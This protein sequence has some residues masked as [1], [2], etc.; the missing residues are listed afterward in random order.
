MDENHIR[1]LIR[2]Y[3]EEEVIRILRNKS[4]YY[5]LVEA[6]FQNNNTQSEVLTENKDA[7]TE[8]KTE[9]VEAVMTI[10]NLK[11]TGIQTVPLIE[12]IARKYGVNTRTLYR[13]VKQYKK[14]G[15]IL[16]RKQRQKGTYRA[17]P[18]DIKEFAIQRYQ[19][20]G[21]KSIVFE[22]V[23]KKMEEKGLPPLGQ[24][25]LYR[26]LLDKEREKLSVVRAEMEP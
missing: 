19:D 8:N 4:L 9:A 16:E 11:F 18:N 7:H 17:I 20:I 10:M 22:E 23:T 24:K 14:S 21:K 25:M 1:E 3:V 6:D 12:E 26:Y 15:K 13:W 2:K 5:A